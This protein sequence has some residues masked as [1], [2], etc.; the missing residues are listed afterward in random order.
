[1]TDPSRTNQ[2]LIE[3]ISVSPSTSSS[4]CSCGHLFKKTPVAVKSLDF[5]VTLG[6]PL[7]FVFM[8]ADAAP[9]VSPGAKEGYFYALDYF[10]LVGAVGGAP[11]TGAG[12]SFKKRDIPRLAESIQPPAG[13]GGF[14]QRGKHFFLKETDRHPC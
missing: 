2:E 10:L 11:P 12:G 9:Q 4:C 7:P 3:E 8:L 1:M 14:L 6:L 5:P 13:A